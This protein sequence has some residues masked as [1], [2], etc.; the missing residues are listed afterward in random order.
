MGAGMRKSSS[1][2]SIILAGLTSLS[3]LTSVPSGGEGHY[4][5]MDEE[6]ESLET[7]GRPMRICNIRFKR[8]TLRTL[9]DRYVDKKGDEK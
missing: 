4:N 2:P 9:E 7:V 8:F 1:R 5:N 3:L 6:D